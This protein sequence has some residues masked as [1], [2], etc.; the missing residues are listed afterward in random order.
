MERFHSFVN[1]WKGVATLIVSIIAILT[2]GS[3]MFDNR[4]D[5]KITEHE[6][7]FELKQQ[8]SV[9]EIKKDVAV[10]KEN[11]RSQQRQLDAIQEQGKHTQE[12]VEEI[13]R[14]IN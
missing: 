5:N 10:L 7:D 4:M 8:E 13:L 11:S 12:L 3:T 6:R 1:S 2:F 14:E 9:G